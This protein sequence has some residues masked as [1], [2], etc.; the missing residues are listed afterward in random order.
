MAAVRWLFTIQISHD[1]L[2]AEKSYPF[3][4]T[5]DSLELHCDGIFCLEFRR[6]PVSRNN[7][8]SAPISEV[9]SLV[10]SH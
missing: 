7:P 6:N 3:S 4:L 10:L 5:T 2:L 8:C 1:K 9:A